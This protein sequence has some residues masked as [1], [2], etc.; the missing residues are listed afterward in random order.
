VVS[1]TKFDY[2]VTLW[3]T[4]DG[5]EIWRIHLPQ[6][7]EK[8]AWTR[9]GTHVASVSEDFVLRL[10]LASDGRIVKEVP[11]EQGID[12]IRVSYD[13]KWLATGEEHTA[14]ASG[15]RSGWIRI[16]SLPDL[17]LIKKLD[18]GATVNELDFTT[19]DRYLVSAGDNGI[20][21]L[22]RT[23]DWS[24]VRDLKRASSGEHAGFVCA[25]FSPDDRYV[26]VSGFGGDVYVWRIADGERIRRFNRTARKNETLE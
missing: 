24:L 1:G 12:S 26:A 19:D 16:F 5:A 13:G 14:S 8:V 25:R 4:S 11:H 17:R 3:R 6:E 15:A 10:I 18:H 2:S 22:W 9:D 20:A 23:A 7:V 21:R